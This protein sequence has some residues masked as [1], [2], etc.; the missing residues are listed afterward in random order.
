MKKQELIKII[1]EELQNTLNELDILDDPVATGAHANLQTRLKDGDPEEIEKAIEF[2]KALGTGQGAA[3]SALLMA[4]GIPAAALPVENAMVKVAVGVFNKLPKPI[5]K[6]L[7]NL[8]LNA[9]KKGT[10]SEAMR[11]F[12]AQASRN[13][14]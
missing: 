3:V 5:Q 4:M 10:G 14:F 1:K 9:Y 7:Y 2:Q 8:G 6:D 13:L 12:L 11:N